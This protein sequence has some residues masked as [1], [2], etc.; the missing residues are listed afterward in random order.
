[1]TFLKICIPIFIVFAVSLTMFGCAAMDF[2]LDEVSIDQS[3]GTIPARVAQNQLAYFPGEP[4]ERYAEQ[5]TGNS[6]AK[7]RVVAELIVQETPTV[8]TSHT[9]DEMI[10]YLCK[11]AW[12]KG[13][14]ALINVH[15]STT[16]VAGGYAR[17]SPV[18]KGQA[19][20]FI[21]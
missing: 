12:E 21:D 2:R 1:M 15:V 20:R 14:D 10:R 6:K 4:S 5:I 8:L 18:V 16:N 19:I 3:Y 7:Y 13:A 11:K 9:A 17:V